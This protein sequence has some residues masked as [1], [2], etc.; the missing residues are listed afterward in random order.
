MSLTKTYRLFGG[1][2]DIDLPADL[3]DASDLRQVPDT[4]EVF[5]ATDSDV[6]VVIEI[7]ERVEPDEPAQAAKFHFDSLAHDNE[8]VSPEVE[9]INTPVVQSSPPVLSILRGTQ[10]VPKFNRTSPDTVKILLA[11]YRVLDKGH[12]LVLTFNIPTQ[13]EKAGSAVSE[14]GLKKWEEAF[15]VAVS[16]FKIVDYGLFA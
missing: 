8:A 11:V 10:R 15:E 2:I 16:S 13:T 14:A 12:D 5:L 9:A 3:L 6:S 7:L 1:A 4:Q